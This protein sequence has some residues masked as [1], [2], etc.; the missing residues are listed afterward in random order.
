MYENSRTFPS[1][2]RQADQTNRP[3][4]INLIE[5]TPHCGPKSTPHD[6]STALHHR[7]I[8]EE[9]VENV[10]AKCDGDG[11]EELER[12]TGVDLQYSVHQVI[13]KIG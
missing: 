4:V 13:M 7:L 10:V 8:E 9:H 2:R 6:S 5:N 3:S 12:E 1:P 11:H